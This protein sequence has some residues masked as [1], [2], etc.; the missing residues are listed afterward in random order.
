MVFEHLAEHLFR[1][2]GKFAAVGQSIDVRAVDQIDAVFDGRPYG[3]LGSSGI[4]LASK[5]QAERNRRDLYTA[6]SKVP[7]FHV[8]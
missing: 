3:A 5:T 8:F 1:R 6:C 4:C 2:S 7:V